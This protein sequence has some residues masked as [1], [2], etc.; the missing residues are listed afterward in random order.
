MLRAADGGRPFAVINPGGEFF[1]A[2]DAAR[3]ESMLDDIRS[4]VNRGGVWWETG[5][6]SFYVCA[7]PDAQGA[8]AQRH[9]GGD[10]ARR[11]G[12]SCA[13]YPVEDPPEALHVTA[14]GREWFGAATVARIEAA[15]SGTQRGFEDDSRSLVLVAGAGGD[16]AAGSR[17]E[18]WGWLFRLGGFNPDPEVAA[19]TVCGS[20]SHLA[21]QPWPTV[22]RPAQLRLWTLRTA[23]P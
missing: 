22:D 5:G 16:L 1:Y 4:Y 9:L 21:S 15:V 12:F 18:G 3:A 2:E 6:Y 7:Y 11:L 23:L 14:V 19:L 20:L 13:G 10:G 8:W 17:G